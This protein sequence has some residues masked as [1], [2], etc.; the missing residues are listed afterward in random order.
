LPVCLSLNGELDVGVYAIYKVK[1][2]NC[3][4][5]WAPSPKPCLKRLCITGDASKPMVITF[6]GGTG[7]RNQYEVQMWCVPTS[8]NWGHLDWDGK[9]YL[10]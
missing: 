3:L 10:K 7:L 9:F 4:G 8:D 1:I 5:I 2:L 6:T